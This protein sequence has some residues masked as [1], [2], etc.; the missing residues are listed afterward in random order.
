M[1]PVT[2]AEV[3]T[4]STINIFHHDESENSSFGYIMFMFGLHHL[5]TPL[6][7]GFRGVRALCSTLFLDYSHSS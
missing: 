2:G 7:S 5:Q 4:L 6:Y 3:R 1:N